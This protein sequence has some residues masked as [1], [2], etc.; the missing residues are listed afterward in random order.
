MFMWKLT[1]TTTLSL[2]V[3][4]CMTMLP[5]GTKTSGYKNIKYTKNLTIHD[6]VYVKCNPV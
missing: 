1:N 3:L 2:D 5:V 6:D 4:R